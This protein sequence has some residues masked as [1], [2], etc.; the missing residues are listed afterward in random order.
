M[1]DAIRTDV[2]LVE[3]YR[4][5]D[6]IERCTGRTSDEAR[7][8]DYDRTVRYVEVDVC[9][10]RYEDVVAYI[11]IADYDCVCADPD[12]IADV[13]RTLPLASELRVDDDARGNVDVVADYALRMDDDAA[14]MRKIKALADVRVIRDLEMVLAAQS[15][16]PPVV[17]VELDLGKLSSAPT[18]LLIVSPSGAICVEPSLIFV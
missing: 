13:R 11:D 10:G 3:Q 5:V 17:Y 16:E 1:L 18:Y 14:E 9:A 12:V 15:V 8:A 6:V 7:I 2:I 4:V